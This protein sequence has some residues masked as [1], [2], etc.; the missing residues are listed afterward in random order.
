MRLKS[1]LPAIWL[2]CAGALLGYGIWES[3]WHFD[4]I[5]KNIWPL[6]VS[7]SLAQAVHAASADL[8]V[9]LV[10]TLKALPL[11]IL[12]GLMAG[13]FLPR[14][15][16]QRV[17]CYSAFL[18]PLAYFAFGYFKI[19]SL[20]AIAW[21]GTEA[22]W[23]SWRVHKVVAFAVYGWYF[24]GLYVGFALAKRRIT[25]QSTGPAASGASRHSQPPG[26]L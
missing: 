19:T 16:F 1:I 17:F 9:P 26:D 20:D 22:L 24:L 10:I 23:Q 2:A 5:P 4:V 14:A 12:I 7:S 21:P 25:H 15:K 11:S 8:D 3:Y 6:I 18:W 13:L